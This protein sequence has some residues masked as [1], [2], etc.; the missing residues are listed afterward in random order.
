MT[1][2]WLYSLII[3]LTST[4]M[5][6]LS[7]AA[8]SENRHQDH[9]AIAQVVTTASKQQAAAQGF[10]DVDVTL[11]KLDANLALPA[12]PTPLT[13]IL[14]Q[15]NQVIG[16]VSV[17]VRCDSEHHQWTIYTRATVTALQR[18]PVF[19]KSLNKGHV[20]TA[21]DLSSKTLPARSTVKDVALDEDQLIGKELTRN[22]NAGS[23]VYLRHLRAPDLI[24]QGQQVMLVARG[25]GVEIKVKGKAQNNGAIGEAVRVTNL[26]SGQTVQGIVE[27]DGSVGIY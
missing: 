2:N 23:P 13:T 26:S 9:A 16:P 15:S 12:C 6:G 20:I 21:A 8:S 3:L 19:S 11:H 1:K 24:K 18:I 22:L 4:L 10:D 25:N 27:A 7:S 5:P 17:G 14:P